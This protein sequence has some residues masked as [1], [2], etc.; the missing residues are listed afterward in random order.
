MLRSVVRTGSNER[1]AVLIVTALLVPAL[2]ICGALAFGV[3]TLWTG[4][5]DVQSAVDLG[6]LAAAAD[7]PTV[8]PE[9]PID[10]QDLFQNLTPGLDPTDW[11]QRACAVA[12]KQFADG[13]SP[14]TNGL[15]A[16]DAAPSCNVSYEWESQLLATLAGC[17]QDVAEL[18]GCRVALEQELRATLPA[19]STL[20][21]SESSAVAGLVNLLSPVS[22]IVTPALA[23]AMPTACAAEVS[24]G[25]LSVSCAATIGT[26]LD[27]IDPTTGALLRP[28]SALLQS[29]IAPLRA[30]AAAGGLDAVGAGV[31]FDST[32]HR[33]QLGVDISRL[34]PALLTPRVHVDVDGMTIKPTFSPMSFDVATGATARRTF[35]SALVLPTLGIPGTSGFASLPPD[36]QASLATAIGAANAAVAATRL[37]GATDGWIV[38]PNLLTK[39]ASDVATQSLDAISA[40]DE[41]VSTPTSTALCSHALPLGTS[42]PVA[43]DPIDED[44]LLGP[45]VQDLRDA[46][47]PP[48]DGDAPSLNDVL[49]H[50][51][52]TGES[53]LVVAAT[54]P[55]YFSKVFGSQVWQTLLHPNIGPSIASQLAP[56]MFIPA[57]DV[58]PATVLRDGNTYRLQRTLATSGLYMARLVK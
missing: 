16:G 1:G 38:D 30:A 29:V 39:S 53:V 37:A 8:S 51:A 36:L 32:T 4:R 2:V 34:A 42:C 55:V 47:R 17:A 19:L 6:A 43:N 45:F 24:V 23:A 15:R 35:K 5:Q 3:T 54:H 13:R 41:S 14:V 10:G 48:P 58:V 52:D 28:L 44:H 49:A 9:L 27:S 22:K 12:Y 25:F 26:L 33:P 56:L 50:Y 31:G 18:E 11:H 57:L 20:D 40:L 7:T 46:T 21:A